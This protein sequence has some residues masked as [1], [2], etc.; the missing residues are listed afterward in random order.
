MKILYNKFDKKLIPGLP[1]VLFEGRIFVVQTETE[2]NKAVDYLAAFPLLGFDTET[3]PSFRKGMMNK[4]SLL[5]LSTDDTCF[6]FRLNHIGMPPSVLRLLQ[7]ERVMKV[8]LS[9]HDDFVSLR[10]RTDFEPKAFL[11]LQEYVKGFGISDLSLQKLYANIFGQKIT[12]GQRLT[13][14]EADVLT[15]GQKLYA[16]TDAWACIRLYRE[17][18]SLRSTGDYELQTVPEKEEGYPQD[19]L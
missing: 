12:K 10:R 9:L 19:G 5:Q 17:M 2:A 8:G 1:R 18:E 3:R 4:V 14:W 15:E 11:D 16:A 6:L 13:N 7:D